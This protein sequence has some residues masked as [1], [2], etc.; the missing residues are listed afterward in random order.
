MGYWGEDGNGIQS[1]ARTYARSK[2]STSTNDTTAPS[3]IDTSIGTNGWASSSPSVTET[4][5]YLWVKEVVTYTKSEATTKYYCI[6]ARGA[7]GVDAQDIEWV[8]IRTKTNVAPVINGDGGSSPYTDH[9]SKTYTSDDHLPKVVAGSGGSLDDI[10]DGNSGSSSKKYECTDDPKGVDSTWKFE[11]E[12]KREKGAADANGHRAWQAYSGTMTLHNRYVKDITSANVW[13]ALADSGTTKPGDSSFT[14]DAFPTTL[15]ADKYVWEATKVTYSDGTSE[16]TAKMC[17]GPT[18][19]F[20]SGTEV[21]AISTSNSTAPAEN[22]TNWKTTYEK[23]KGYYLWT[24]TRVQY[25]NGSY[26]YLNKKCVGYW[27]EDGNQGYSIALT[28]IRNNLYTDANWDAYATIGHNESY[29]KRTGDSDLT[30]CRVG[31]YFV[32][33]GTSSD[34]GKNHTA[35]YKCTSVASDKIY[36]DCVS[37]TKDGTNGQSA[38]YDV[39]TYGRSKSRSSYSSSYLDTSYGTNGWSSTAPSA[40]TTYPY[41]WEKIEHYNSA[42]TYQSTSYVCLTGSDGITGPRGKMSRNL[43]YAGLMSEVG[44]KTFNA[45]D[46]QAP[47]VN[48]GTDDDPH[49][50]AYVGSN[51]TGISYPNSA[52]SYTPSNGWEEMTT[53][54]RYLIAKAV[55]SEYAKLGSAVFNKDFMF[56]Q[57]LNNELTMHTATYTRSAESYAIVTSQVSLPVV[58][59]T[60]YRISVTCWRNSSY[61]TGIYAWVFYLESVY[62][63]TDSNW[64]SHNIIGKEFFSTSEISE[65]THDI[66]FTAEKTGYVRIG[67]YGY[68]YI[69]TIKASVSDCYDKVSPMFINSDPVPL[70][71]TAGN[72]T[73]STSYVDI[74]TIPIPI[75]QGRTYQLKLNSYVTNTSYYGYVGVYYNGNIRHSLYFNNAY[76]SA[77]MAKTYTFTA[78][79]TG[80]AYLKFSVS[81]AN[82]TV[83][84]NKIYILC[85]D[86]FVP[87]AAVNWLTGYAHFAGDRVRFNPD[88]SGHMAGGRLSWDKRGNISMKGTDDALSLTTENDKMYTVVQAGHIEIRSKTTQSFGIFEINALGEIILSMYDKD[89]NCVINLGGTPNTLVNGEWVRWKLCPKAA[90][91][92]SDGKT[93]YAV[94]EEECTTYY[95]LKLGQ[96]KNTDNALQYYLPPAWNASEGKQTTDA[97]VIARDKK[98]FTSYSTSSVQSTM[99]SEI[100]GLT[101]LLDGYYVK[102]NNGRFEVEA[103]IEGPTNYTVDLYFFSGGILQNIFVQHF[104]L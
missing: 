102:P 40:T 32:V 17:L 94:T 42:G 50:Y 72:S 82:T 95:Q 96:V 31:D 44:G 9:N 66:V 41:I 49:C 79:Y 28:L 51:G 65:S 2:N 48:I 91:H 14:L 11:W 101:T 55:F 78:T 25:T 86:A 43:W 23:T 47:Y 67:A 46:Y 19:D 57:Y 33:T 60:Q 99:E 68:G 18:T 71:V 98:V 22:T 97:D 59:G 4:Y 103:N 87:T 93:Y 88:G 34:S 21:Y 73:N 76:G 36:G 39:V 16:F 100:K 56:S 6:G 27:G 53:D 35:I 12:I 58:A 29:V 10:E 20:L 74:N 90:G 80:Y 69:T 26:A 61:S 83:Y 13:Y 30:A 89:G 24:A 63:D 64:N 1:V 77:D 3:N 92:T 37:H 81:N 15:N 7:N 75:V 54:F 8:Y 70:Q 38:P 104:S 5:P 45:D 84:V 62:D 85:T 52:S